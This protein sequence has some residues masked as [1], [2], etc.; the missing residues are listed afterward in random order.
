MGSTLT[1]MINLADAFITQINPL[2]SAL[3][4]STFLGGQGEDEAAGVSVDR[5]GD[6]YII[7]STGYG[8]RSDFPVVRSVQPKRGGP[9]T[10]VFI[11]KISSQPIH[12]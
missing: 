6:I 10:N 3:L 11:T 12:N 7:G 2:G 1:S 5:F 8:D 9:T 4:F